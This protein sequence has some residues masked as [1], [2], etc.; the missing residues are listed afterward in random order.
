MPPSPE[1]LGQPLPR[2]PI[3]ALTL[4]HLSPASGS[5][6]ALTKSLPTGISDSLGA[7]ERLQRDGSGLGIPTPTTLHAW[8]LVLAGSRR[9]THGASA[10]S[11]RPQG[12]SF[13]LPLKPGHPAS[14]LREERGEGIACYERN[15]DYLRIYTTH[16]LMML[17]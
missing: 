3:H 13:T 7:L 6:P 12:R 17:T 14:G 8:P 2:P 15:W 9:L 16:T 5:R 4:V 10:G 11:S 1:A